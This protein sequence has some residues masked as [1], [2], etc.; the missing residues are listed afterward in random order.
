MRLAPDGGSP[1]SPPPP[2]SGPHRGSDMEV[3]PPPRAYSPQIANGLEQKNPPKTAPHCAYCHIIG[4][5]TSPNLPST[6][7]CRA[8]KNTI[9]LQ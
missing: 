1:P 9:H 7:Q 6:F 5:P 8:T 4:A 3:N 2:Q